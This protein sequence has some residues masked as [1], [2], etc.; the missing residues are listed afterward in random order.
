MEQRATSIVE[1]ED[2]RSAVPGEHR[3]PGGRTQTMQGEGGEAA[4]GCPAGASGTSEQQ[5]RRRLSGS[6]AARA[7]SS[8]TEKKR[9][10]FPF[11]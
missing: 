10:S 8:L 2:R 9:F 1:P 7:R 6:G 11:W 3:P 4:P 5:V